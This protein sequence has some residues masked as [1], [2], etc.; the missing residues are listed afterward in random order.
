[1]TDF[2]ALHV[3]GD[4]L[5]LPNPWDVGSA[6]VLEA[7]GFRALAT[8]SSGAAATMGRL[9][10]GLSRDEAIAGAAA[11]AAAVA[12]PVSADLEHCFADEPEGVADTVRL[13]RDAGLAGCS[14]EDWDPVRKQLYPF[15]LAVERVRAAID[16]AGGLVITARAEG[17][18]RGG[19]V[20][21]AIERVQAFA[22][23]GAP[24]VFVPGLRAADDIR[25][26]VDAV[27]VPVNVLARPGVPTVPE[28]AALGVGRVSVG[29]SFAWAAYDALVQAATELRDGGTYGYWANI[30]RSFDT[31]R[32]ALG[33]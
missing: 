27:D 9:D 5:L 30:E 2:L 22:A 12:V 13:A 23:A 6:R 32:R 15:E 10:G 18:L 8:T 33:A 29:G 7:L 24:V 31:V 21:A 14:V 1:M 17:V 25:A 16:A 4:P 11:I 20:A 26:V 19:D 28:L 3:K